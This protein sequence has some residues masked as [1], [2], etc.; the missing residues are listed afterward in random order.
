MDWE[1]II[2]YRNQ[3]WKAFL[4][5]TETFDLVIIVSLYV[6]EMYHQLISLGVDSGRKIKERA[7]ASDSVR[8]FGELTRT[9]LDEIL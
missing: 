1:I 3:S 6:S 4:T 8:L 2:A 7:E 9:E 5:L